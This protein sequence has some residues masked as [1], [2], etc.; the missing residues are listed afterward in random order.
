MPSLLP[1]LLLGAVGV[2]LF[3]LALPHIRRS[4]LVD[5][6]KRFDHARALTT[7]WSER[8]RDN[9]DT[10]TGPGAGPPP[11]DAPTGG[12]PSAGTPTAGTPTAGTPTAGTP[13]AGASGAGASGGG[14]SGGN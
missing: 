1:Y 11:A 6:V 9:S 2:V 12:T 10:V 7:T 3:L 14:K 5:E 4:N 13:T 8:A